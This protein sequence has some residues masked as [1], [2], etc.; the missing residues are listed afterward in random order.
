M[1]YFDQVGLKYNSKWIIKDL[2]FEVKKGEKIIIQGKSGVG[3]SSIYSLLLGFTQPVSGDIFFNQLPIN[4]QTTW[5]VRRQIALIDQNISLGKGVVRNFINYISHL[6]A[7]PSNKFHPRKMHVLLEYFLLKEDQLDADFDDLSGGERQRLAIIL[8]ILLERPV[9]LLDEVTSA[10]DND[11][12][13]K[14][15][16]FFMGLKDRTV[17]AI[18][19]D[20]VWYD[21]P[22]VKIFNLEKRK[23]TR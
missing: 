19:H 1:I 4:E 21:Y 12:K 5:M 16:N 9:F 6:K 15:A 2:C 18:S 11:L 8:C 14:V 22:H 23:W 20:P 3:K 17:L 7:I 10:L 13:K